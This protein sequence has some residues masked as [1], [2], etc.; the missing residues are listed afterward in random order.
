MCRDCEEMTTALVCGCILCDTCVIRYQEHDSNCGVPSHGPL[1]RD[2]HNIQDIFDSDSLLFSSDSAPQNVSFIISFTGMKRKRD[3]FTFQRHLEEDYHMPVLN[4]KYSDYL[5]ET[6]DDT[7]SYKFPFDALYTIAIPFVIELANEFC[8]Q[9]CESEATDYYGFAF[10]CEVEK[11]DPQ[12]L[13]LMGSEELIETAILLRR[14]E[15]QFKEDRE[16]ISQQQAAETNELIATGQLQ[17]MA[18]FDIET[19]QELTNSAHADLEPGEGGRCIVFEDLREVQKR[20]YHYPVHGALLVDEYKCR[21]FLPTG[22][23]E[24]TY[25]LISFP[26][27]IQ[28]I[29]N[30]RTD[31]VSHAT[32]TPKR[33]G[34]V[35]YKEIEGNMTPYYE[36]MFADYEFERIRHSDPPLCR[37]FATKTFEMDQKHHEF[38][39][40]SELEKAK[41]TPRRNSGNCVPSKLRLTG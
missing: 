25:E 7:V 8:L 37:I 4:E 32:L 22:E 39:N 30:P 23:D 34:C 28:E 18:E 19:G 21:V 16:A 15:K 35:D 24:G 31:L 11:E 6:Y 38:M 5:L 10:Y 29:E 14:V 17:H 36:T 26:S 40:I 9:N 41:F 13:K 3:F 1:K 27:M 12:R 2:T 33:L 20:S